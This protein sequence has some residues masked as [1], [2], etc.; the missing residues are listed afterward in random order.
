MNSLQPIWKHEEADDERYFPNYEFLSTI[1]GHDIWYAKPIPKKQA[2]LIQIRFGN[3]DRDWEFMNLR[4]M[5]ALN[6]RNNAAFKA[7]YPLFFEAFQ[8]LK[9][10][11]IV[12]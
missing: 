10:K 8:V 4:N 12:K 7:I 3:D 6:E 2:A 1:E 11:G 5:K 9:S